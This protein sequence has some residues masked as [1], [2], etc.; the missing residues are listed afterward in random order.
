M[1]SRKA[2]LDR[3]LSLPVSPQQG[4]LFNNVSDIFCRVCKI[5]HIFSV[6]HWTLYEAVCFQF[7]HFPC[8][9]WE[10]IYFVLLSSSYRKYELLNMHCLGSGHETMAYAACLLIFL[11]LNWDHDKDGSE[12][13][14]RLIVKKI[15][16]CWLPNSPHNNS[17]QQ[18]N[19]RKI[20]HGVCQFG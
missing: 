6:I 14:L 15:F 17:F 10:N 11:W 4:I 16:C 1:Y 5:G 9:D 20:P 3:E 2:L 13:V 12:T 8:D 19:A 18:D 7:A